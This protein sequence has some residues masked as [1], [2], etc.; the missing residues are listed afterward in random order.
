MMG[1]YKVDLLA[2]RDDFAGY[3]KVYRVSNSERGFFVVYN[4]SYETIELMDR[5]QMIKWFLDSDG[6]EKEELK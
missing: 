6:S 3:Y 5:S 1:K 4:T 2:I